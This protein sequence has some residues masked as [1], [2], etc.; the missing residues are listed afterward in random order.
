[1]AW[2]VVYVG[3]LPIGGITGF[4]KLSMSLSTEVAAIVGGKN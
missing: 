1:M 3:L 2:I 4:S